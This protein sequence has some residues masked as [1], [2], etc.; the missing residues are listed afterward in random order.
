MT[1]YITPDNKLHDDADGFALTL[2]SW[3]LDARVATQDEIEA[4]QNPA[5]LPEE[6]RA[7]LSALNA[8]QIRKVLTQYGLRK[9]VEDAVLNADQNTQDA[10][11]YA[12]SFKR[13][14]AILNGMA[15]QLSISDEQ[16]DSMFELGITL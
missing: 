2:D 15:V 13:D 5:I 9:Q 16:L 12:T 1:I 10:W 8:W 11:H 7:L 4:I 6:K 14:D 3:P